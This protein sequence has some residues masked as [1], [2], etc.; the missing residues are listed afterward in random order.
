VHLFRGG[1]VTVSS[2]TGR[3]RAEGRLQAVRQLD[4]AVRYVIDGEPIDVPFASQ[5]IA[6][7]EVAAAQNAMRTAGFVLGEGREGPGA[8]RS[9][10]SSALLD[11]SPALPPSMPPLGSLLSSPLKH[12][13]HAPATP[14]I[15]FH[16]LSAL[17]RASP[18]AFPA[19]YIE[20]ELPENT[21]VLYGTGQEDGLTPE[22]GPKEPGSSPGEGRAAAPN[23][24][25]R[26]RPTAAAATP[27]FHAV[28]GP[29]PMVVWR[30]AERED[31][32]P[33]ADEDR[34]AL[35]ARLRAAAAPVM[36]AWAD[37]VLEPHVPA[38]GALVWRMV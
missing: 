19:G 31:R 14:H 26:P 4:A 9:G 11:A 35:L 29:L 6:R 10:S 13:T 37:P 12:I 25:A 28:P 30:S 16:L 1:R 17:E 20:V 34:I 33:G 8:F 15:A 18:D 38:A 24:R 23:E 7:Q 21:W 22:M 2:S 32:R 36:L 27:V 3:R 5:E